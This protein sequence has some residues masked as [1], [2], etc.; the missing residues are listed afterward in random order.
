MKIEDFGYSVVKMRHGN[1]GKYSLDCKILVMDLVPN[2]QNVKE[3]SNKTSNLK[4]RHT[5]DFYNITWIE[6]GGG[7]L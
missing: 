6:K 7:L 2:L 4:D 5:H 1:V 3:I